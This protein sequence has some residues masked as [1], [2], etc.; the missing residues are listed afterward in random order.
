[1]RQ[2]ATSV[3]LAVAMARH[4][5]AGSIWD[6]GT[7]MVEPSM[8][9]ALTGG[10]HF[11]DPEWRTVAEA[12]SRRSDAG[13]PISALFGGAGPPGKRLMFVR[14]GSTSSRW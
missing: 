7:G 3:L 11:P 14:P 9:V 1:M 13:F 4:A 10:G 8:K 5:V 2:A 6:Y 12:L